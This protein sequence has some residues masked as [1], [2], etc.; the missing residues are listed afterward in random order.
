MIALIKE[1]LH[2]PFR[3]IRAGGQILTDRKLFAYCIIPLIIGI[4]TLLISITTVF[5][6]RNEIGAAL[7]TSHNTWSATLISFI[8]LL[9]SI[10]FSGMVSFVVT[11]ALS[12]FFIEEFVDTL[13]IRQGY[14][15]PTASGTLPI[16][17]SI[18]RGLVDSIQQLVFL[19]ILSG[20]LLLT[21]LVP[22][23]TLP[24]L[25][26]TAF[27]T[28]A[29]LVDTPLT[30][31]GYR[32]SDRWQW[33]LHHKCWCLLIGTILMLAMI[34]PLGATI[35]LPILLLVSVEKLKEWGIKSL[36]QTF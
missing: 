27:I 3:C 24:I 21:G 2:F 6:Y 5:I 35:M 18:L 26:V 22:F 14:K 12:S 13:L 1:L 29:N 28:G 25:F 9:L 17:K 23:F 31:L 16:I 10:P 19:S 7:V 20:V 34:I 30:L 8:V 11:L 33:A 15:R 32:F 36:H 4:T